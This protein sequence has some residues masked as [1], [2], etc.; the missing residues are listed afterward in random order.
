MTQT[1]STIPTVVDVAHYGGDTLYLRVEVDAD[2]VAGRDWDAQV[3]RSRESDEIDAIFA[4]VEGSHAGETYLMLPGEVVTA[5]VTAWGTE[6]RVQGK[7][8]MR[9]VGV[10]DVQVSAGG[11]DPITTLAQ[12]ALT[13]DLDVTRRPTS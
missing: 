3:R 2:V 10:W 4:I 8:T 12:G 9:Y 7:K 1:L 6:V 5:L 11:T 13:I